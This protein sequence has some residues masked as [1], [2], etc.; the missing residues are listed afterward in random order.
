MNHTP[1]PWIYCNNSGLHRNI[2]AGSK[3]IARVDGNEHDEETADANAHLIAAAPRL[4]EALQFA[5]ERLKIVEKEDG[6]DHRTFHQGVAIDKA[7]AAI[8]KATGEKK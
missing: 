2:W 7:I 5:L 4:L 1:S 3:M 6:Y 8:A